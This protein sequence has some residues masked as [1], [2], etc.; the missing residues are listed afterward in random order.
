M[1]N[2]W[3]NW[4][5]NLGSSHSKNPTTV[6]CQFSFLSLR[7]SHKSFQQSNIL[8]LR[9]TALLPAQQPLCHSAFP[10]GT[11]Q[12]SIPGLPPASAVSPHVAPLSQESGGRLLPQ[13]NEEKQGMK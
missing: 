8:I 3:N 13:K 4:G 11:K 5:L 9:I 6:L 1:I 2:E 10:P 7:S 12:E